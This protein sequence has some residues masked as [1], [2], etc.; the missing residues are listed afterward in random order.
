MEEPLGVR[1]RRGQAKFR[2]SLIAAYGGKCA[3]TGCNAIE[4]LEAAHIAPHRGAYTDHPKNGLLLRADQHS[5]FDLGL[6]SVDPSTMTVVI[7]MQ[8]AKSSYANLAGKQIVTPS[9]L[10]LKPCT[11]ALERHLERSAITKASPR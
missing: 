7:S 2:A 8:L 11:E 3:I 9:E 5:L 1:R 6:V 4:A 10:P